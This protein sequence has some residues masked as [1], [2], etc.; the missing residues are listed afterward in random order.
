MWFWIVLLLAVNIIA[1]KCIKNDKNRARRSIYRIPER[2]LLILA[3]LGGSIGIL[4]GMYRYR[5]KTQKPSFYIGVPA[6]LAV[7]VF[8][9]LYYLFSLIK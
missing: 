1:Y 2:T 6:I 3:L 9:L 5:H 7:Q 8:L 4:V